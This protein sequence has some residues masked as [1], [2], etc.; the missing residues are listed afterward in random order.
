MGVPGEWSWGYPHFIGSRML[1][2]GEGRTLP[3]ISQPR[4]G[5]PQTWVCCHPLLAE[6]LPQLRDGNNTTRFQNCHQGDLMWAA[7]RR[8]STNEGSWLCG[9][10]VNFGLLRVCGHDPNQA[11]HECRYWPSPPT[12]K[13]GGHE[14]GLPRPALLPSLPPKM[15][16]A[17]DDRQLFLGQ[18]LH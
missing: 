15:T 17:G 12:P 11:A 4:V 2:L 13:A 5:R 10:S 1:R 14:I 9:G 8:P 16:A 18:G 3:K 7:H 6:P